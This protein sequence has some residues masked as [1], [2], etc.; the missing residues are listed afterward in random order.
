MAYDL[1]VFQT[2]TSIF[3]VIHLILFLIVLFE[4]L[5]IERS[6]VKKVSWGTFVFFFPIFGLITYFLFSSREEHDRRYHVLD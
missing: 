6:I 3:G 2:C 1:T 4:I 5:Q